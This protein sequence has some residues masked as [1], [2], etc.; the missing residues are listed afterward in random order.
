[1]NYALDNYAGTDANGI[2]VATIMSSMWSHF[3]KHGTPNIP[4]VQ[5]ATWPEY[6]TETDINL[7]ITQTP[8]ILGGS[9][10]SRDGILIWF[11]V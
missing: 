11:S 8:R 4:G 3:A 2:A 9:S 5:W 10:G 6:D 1:M 7:E